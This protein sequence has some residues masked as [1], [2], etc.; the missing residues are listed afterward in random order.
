MANI[1][2]V[3]RDE[4]IRLAR[5]EVR[6]E[7]EGLR[8]ASSSYRSEIAELKRRI[9]T[10]EKQ[11]ARPQTKPLLKTGTSTYADSPKKSRFNSK[12]FAAHRERLG[13]SAAD[14]GLIIGVT[15]H[16]VYLWE[17]GAKP[18]ERYMDA[19]AAFRKLGKR[20]AKAL[21]EKAKD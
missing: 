7:I 8:K 9:I 21:L 5:R 14:A 4:M 3:L 10:L 6:K 16:T 12:G 1:G 15:G 13:L 17:G 18:R 19:I 11:A 20:D 2:T